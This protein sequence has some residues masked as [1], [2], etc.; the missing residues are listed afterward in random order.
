M[1]IEVGQQV[2]PPGPGIR[3]NDAVGIHQHQLFNAV[4]EMQRKAEGD[5]TS[6]RKANQA[7]LLQLQHVQQMIHKSDIKIG[8]V[9]DIWLVTEPI[10]WQIWRKDTMMRR[11][12]RDGIIPGKACRVQASAMQENK[13]RATP[14]G[15]ETMNTHSVDVEPD[16]LYPCL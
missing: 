5:C 2:H 8:R 9:L 16:F 12:W 10:A 1:D 3:A 13:R 11:L 15:S 14:T 6:H 7:D 4:R